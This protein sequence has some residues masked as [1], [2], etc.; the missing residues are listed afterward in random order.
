MVKLNK[1]GKY[2]NSVK[3]QE[4][5]NSI[6]KM[7]QVKN[8][9]FKHFVELAGADGNAWVL[10]QIELISFEE[11]SHLSELLYLL[12]EFVGENEPAYADIFGQLQM[13]VSQMKKICNTPA[14]NFDSVV[15]G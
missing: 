14:H 13:E 8:D 1:P 12:R 4:L 2:G 5:M 7:I 9:V 10:Q 15:N 6:R 11:R 3:K